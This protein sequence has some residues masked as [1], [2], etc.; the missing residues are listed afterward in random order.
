VLAILLA[1][2]SALLFGTTDF[3]GGVL[4]RRAPAWSV[5]FM[6]LLGATVVTAGLASTQ[7]GSPVR[8]DYLWATVGGVGGGVAMAFIYRGLSKGRMGVVAPISAVGTTVIS[9][10]G[11]LLAGERPG[12]VVWV[13]ILL[14]VPAIVLISRDKAVVSPASATAWA[15]VADGL[16]GSVGGGAMLV[17]LGQIPDSSGWWPAACLQLVSMLTVVPLAL[18][19][20]ECWFPR[21]RASV[22][23]LA[24]GPLAASAGILFLVATQHGD[25][26]VAGV[27]VSLYPAATVVLA[28]LFLRE[29]VHGVQVAGLLLCAAAVSCVALG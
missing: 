11:G 7:P 2:T 4:S 16:I 29:R 6:G 12:A 1:T 10:P 19:F 14:A 21:T 22:L 23:G 8:S 20:G 24:T 27:I 9:V 5:T 15:G 3:L 13:G 25:L 26:A 17:S 18:I 28:V